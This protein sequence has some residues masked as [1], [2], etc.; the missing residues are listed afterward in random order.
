MVVRET[1]G[2][3]A[4]S[5]CGGKRPRVAGA[6]GRRWEGGKREKGVNGR[7]EMWR[8]YIGSSKSQ[9]IPEPKRTRSNFPIWRRRANP[10]SRRMIS[11]A[12]PQIQASKQASKKRLGRTNRDPQNPALHTTTQYKTH[13]SSPTRKSRPKRASKA[14]KLRKENPPPQGHRAAGCAVGLHRAAR[15]WPERENAKPAACRPARPKSREMRLAHRE[16][17]DKRARDHRS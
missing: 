8:L 15:N 3:G 16:G 13:K 10:I 5:G 9:R 2:V 7:G 4:R 6:E 14:P 11:S 17:H 1:M 12:T